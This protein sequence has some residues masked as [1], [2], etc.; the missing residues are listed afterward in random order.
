M[1]ARSAAVSTLS[2]FAI[3]F[4]ISTPGL[5]EGRR[6]TQSGTEGFCLGQKCSFCAELCTWGVKK[7]GTKR[8]ERA[9]KVSLGARKGNFD[10]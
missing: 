3:Q 4:S 7:L 10:F 8:R 2:L 9:K 5:G 6:E 1:G